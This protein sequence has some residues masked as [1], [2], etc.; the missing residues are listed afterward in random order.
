MK[1]YVARKGPRWYAV[2]YEGMDPVTGRER[3][4]WHNLRHTHGT[5]LKA[6]GVPVKVERPP[7]THDA[8]VHHRDLPARPA[9]HAPT[10]PVCSNSSSS[11]AF[12]RR[13]TRGRRSGEASEK[14]AWLR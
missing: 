5:L 11:P 1:G 12:Y 7:R 13:R 8:D 10:P 2:T 14:S 9:G 4:S 6:A 3:R